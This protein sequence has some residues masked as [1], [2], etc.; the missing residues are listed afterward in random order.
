MKF[1]ITLDQQI[2][3]LKAELAIRTSEV[4]AAHKKF[5]AMRAALHTLI[6]LQRSFEVKPGVKLWPLGELARDREEEG[7]PPD[8]DKA[9]GDRA[10]HG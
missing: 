3:E 6:E 1:T 9:A 8:A 4:E 7:L 10:Q 5:A 2:S